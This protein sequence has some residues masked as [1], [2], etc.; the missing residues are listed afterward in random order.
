M[1]MLY[2]SDSYV[3]VRFDVAGSGDPATP[4]LTRGGYEIVD[5]RAGREIFLDGLLAEHFRQG[6]QALVDGEPDEDAM[7]AFIGRWTVL[8]QQPLALH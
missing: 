8:A 6:V 5:R 3:V 4:A 7:D 1:Q 2:H